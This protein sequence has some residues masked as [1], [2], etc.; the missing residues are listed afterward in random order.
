M[1]DNGGIISQPCRR[2]HQSAAAK[3]SRSVKTWTPMN[4][5]VT[6]QPYR[7]GHQSAATEVGRRREHQLTATK[8]V[9]SEDDDAHQQR[10]MERRSPVSVSRTGT[11]VGLGSVEAA[12]RELVETVD[13]VS[14]CSQPCRRRCPAIVSAANARTYQVDTPRHGDGLTTTASQ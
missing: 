1:P 12:N 9:D 3:A 5:G 2:R 14:G 8:T 10:P 11:I 4:G 6:N 7:R 13:S